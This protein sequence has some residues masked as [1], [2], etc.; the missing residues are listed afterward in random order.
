MKFSSFFAGSKG[1][2]SQ[3]TICAMA[4]ESVPIATLGG[5]FLNNFYVS[6]APKA[7]K[8]PTPWHVRFVPG[9]DM[10]RSLEHLSRIY[11]AGR[12]RDRLPSGIYFEH[13]RG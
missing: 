8:E 13:P 7:D 11:Q 6:F 1:R 10:S 5:E 4:G 3:R 2:V 9:A 12:R